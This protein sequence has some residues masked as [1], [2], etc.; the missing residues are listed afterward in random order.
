MTY[1]QVLIA[2]FFLFTLLFALMLILRPW[3]NV[4]FRPGTEGIARGLMT[5]SVAVLFLLMAFFL[6]VLLATAWANPNAPDT[7][8]PTST[9][10]FLA[11]PLLCV[12]ILVYKEMQ[13]RRRSHSG[14]L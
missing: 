10:L 13:V 14:S 3:R 7:I 12:G 8:V 11:I 5:F 4:Q 2:S 1:S 6:V 9:Y